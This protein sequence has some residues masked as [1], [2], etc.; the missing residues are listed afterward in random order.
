MRETRIPGKMRFPPLLKSAAALLRVSTARGVEGAPSSAS[1]VAADQKRDTAKLNVGRC[2]KMAPL[3][4]SKMSER[5]VDGSLGINAT[6]KTATTEGDIL[7]G[8]LAGD[9]AAR[10]VCHYLRRRREDRRSCPR[11]AEEGNG[12]GKGRFARCSREAGR[13]LVGELGATTK[14]G[15]SQ[16]QGGAGLP[17]R[18]VG[19]LAPCLVQ[20]KAIADRGH[21][22]S[23][24]AS[25]R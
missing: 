19:L 24:S 9:K 7:L 11:A 15:F 22:T 1:R 17:I 6:M 18:A 20:G 10:K 2:K 25:L 8:L 23:R 4:S 12:G 5:R 16:E 14:I 21:F 3:G 13:A